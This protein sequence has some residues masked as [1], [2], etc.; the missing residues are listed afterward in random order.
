[1]LRPQLASVWPVTAY[2]D[3]EPS[4]AGL[5][6]PARDAHEVIRQWVDIETHSVRA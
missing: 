5:V 6:A 4:R 2:R 1:M 3:G